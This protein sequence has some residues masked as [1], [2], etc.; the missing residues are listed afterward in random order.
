MKTK[1][2]IIREI[3][4]LTEDTLGVVLKFILTLEK[5]F[6]KT[7]QAEESQWGTL[8]L[9]SGAFDFWL[10]PDEVEYTLD[11]LKERK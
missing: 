5:G 8:A 7:R 4:S 2:R 11:D 9:E 3:E 6:T 10:N 1:E